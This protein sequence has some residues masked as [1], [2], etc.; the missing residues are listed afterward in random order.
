VTNPSNFFFL[1]SKVIPSSPVAF[2]TYLKEIMFGHHM[3]RMH[4]RNRLTKFCILR[5]I[6]LETLDSHSYKSSDFTLTLQ[7]LMLV[8]F[9][10][11]ADSRTSLSL[12]KDPIA[13]CILTLISALSR[14]SNAGISEIY[15]VLIYFK[16]NLRYPLT[17]L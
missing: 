2:H 10:I 1:F 6:S 16:L 11:D 4:K 5:L 17:I 14:N 9:R 15:F 7:F 13:L 12:Q 8:P 3:T